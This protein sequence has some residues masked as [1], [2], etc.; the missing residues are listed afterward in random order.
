MKTVEHACAQGRA[1]QT[2]ILH[3]LFIWKVEKRTTLT[4]FEHQ[5]NQKRMN[6]TGSYK[7]HNYDSLQAACQ[8]IQKKETFFNYSFGTLPKILS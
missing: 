8:S 4:S 1:M 5:N 7:G 6:G 3:S 2:C